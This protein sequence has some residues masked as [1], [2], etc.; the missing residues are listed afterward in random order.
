M[1]REFLRAA[2][3]RVQFILAQREHDH[4]RTVQIN[5][6]YSRIRPAG[7]KKMAGHR[8][9]L[10]EKYKNLERE[11][12]RAVFRLA[13]THSIAQE[14]DPRLNR[15]ILG[16]KETLA[17][18]QT[19]LDI[20]TRKHLAETGEKPEEAMKREY[21][22]AEEEVKALRNTFDLTQTE[23][24]DSWG[25][26]ITLQELWERYKG[27]EEKTP[28]PPEYVAF[29]LSLDDLRK[30]F[31]QM[32]PGIQKLVSSVTSL[33]TEMVEELEYKATVQ[34]QKQ[35]LIDMK[36]QVCIRLSVFF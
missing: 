2:G 23:I 34:E 31:N 12:Q 3:L 5:P 25:E 1:Y 27:W 10:F 4:F 30:Q 8:Q 9:Y 35:E 7:E 33:T 36:L 21:E 29:H 17:V 22:V 28:P 15:A 14:E 32:G 24:Y 18:L 26:F 16:A 19:E 6:F 13:E 11:A 20:V